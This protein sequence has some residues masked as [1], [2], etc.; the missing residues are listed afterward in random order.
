MPFEKIKIAKVADVIVE[1][2]EQMI[3]SGVL[4]PAEK[5]PSE[6]EL[7]QQL[8][9]SRPSLREALFK[10]EAKDL[11]ESRHGGGTYVKSVLGPTF[12]D[13]LGRLLQSH[14]EAAADY[15]EFR[16]VM[17]G[18]AAALAAVRHTEA[19]REIITAQF[20]RMEQ[21]QANRKLSREADADADFHL[22]ISEATHNVILLHIMRG[23]FNLLQQEIFHNR[24]RLY[25]REGAQAALLQQHRD[26]LEAVLARDPDAA[27]SAAQ[28]HLSYVQ[29]AFEE[30]GVEWGREHTAHQRLERL[31]QELPSG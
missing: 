8:D 10:L 21:A 6:R 9:V 4:K 16:K 19:D 20:N 7:A 25:T 24:H 30:M 13:P 3:L 27:R 1:Q 18:E 23:L 2:L 12:T 28:A 15:L 29:Q 11:I 26:L 31:R 5:L 14:P 22:A 17:E